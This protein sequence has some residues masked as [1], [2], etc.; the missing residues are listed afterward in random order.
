MLLIGD[1]VWHEPKLHRPELPSLE[2]DDYTR[3]VKEYEM[4]EV[5]LLLSQAKAIITC[6]AG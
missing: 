4:S 3:A 6:N 2:E 1:M 5:F